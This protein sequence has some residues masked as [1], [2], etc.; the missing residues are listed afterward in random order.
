[1]LTINKRWIGRAFA[2]ADGDLLQLN[3]QLKSCR[4][5]KMGRLSV[6]ESQTAGAHRIWYCIG[7]IVKTSDDFDTQA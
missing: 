4:F 7:W 6:H 2:S 3:G 5:Q 1:V